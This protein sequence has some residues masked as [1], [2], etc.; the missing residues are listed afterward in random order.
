VTQLKKI[1]HYRNVFLIFWLFPIF[2]LPFRWL[3]AVVK[4]AEILGAINGTGWLVL[5]N[6]PVIG[7]LYFLLTVALVW[8]HFSRVKEV[9]A[10]LYFAC[11]VSFTTGIVLLPRIILGPTGL[12]QSGLFDSQAYYSLYVIAL[13]PAFYL[14]V[15][16]LL[17][18]VITFF[19]FH[20]LPIRKDRQL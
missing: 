1:M 14:V 19:I 20:I 18:T 7:W 4:D 2:L 15:S 11:L 6:F 17:L 10:P 9:V 8:L 5:K 16:S 12:S 13:K 3:S